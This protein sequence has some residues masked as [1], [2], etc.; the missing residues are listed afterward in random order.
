M[1]YTHF[2]KELC[3]KLV[4]A[5]WILSCDSNRNDTYIK[6]SELGVAHKA[7]FIEDVNKIFPCHT[8]ELKKLLKAFG[9]YHGLIELSELEKIK[10]RAWWLISE[11]P[12]ILVTCDSRGN[13]EYALFQSRDD[14]AAYQLML[15]AN[16]EEKEIVILESRW[17]KEG[18]LP[19]LTPF[20][21][22]GYWIKND[23]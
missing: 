16:R 17:L 10:S 19:R 4:Q 22:R 1:D 15:A 21:A 7:T 18:K 3:E 14:E 12:Y 5:G 9:Q 2:E 8:D 23:A 13:A 11:G 6:W 20:G